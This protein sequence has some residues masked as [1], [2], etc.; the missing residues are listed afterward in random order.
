MLHALNNLA[1]GVGYLVLVLW[2]WGFVALIGYGL[3]QRLRTKHLFHT[4]MN[5][6]AV[7][8]ARAR[9]HG[10]MYVEEPNGTLTTLVG[11]EQMGDLWPSD[12]R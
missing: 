4:A 12:I 10:T 7:I 6:N 5:A 1:L 8:V 9:Q 3:R 11:V 2:F